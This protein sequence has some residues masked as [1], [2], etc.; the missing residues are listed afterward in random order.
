MHLIPPPS[1]QLV[2]CLLNAIHTLHTEYH[3]LYRNWCID[4]L[5]LLDN[6]YACLMDFRFAKRDEGHCLTLCGP[7]SAVSP[8]V[9]RGEVQGPATDIWGLGTLLYELFTGDSPWG[10]Y[11]EDTTILKR[12][13][14][15]KGGLDMPFVDPKHAS[16]LNLLLDPN[17]SNRPSSQTLQ[18]HAWFS[19]VQ[20]SRVLSGEIRSPIAEVAREQSVVRLSEGARDELVEVEIS[21]EID[22]SLFGNLS[23]F[24]AAK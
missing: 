6:G 8:E 20:W 3:T 14:A 5:H 13:A 19:D 7:L 17:P 1:S 11:E 23:Q 22:E 10:S 16:L 4:H 18:E 12:I 21:P 24:G 2:V 9:V 15:H